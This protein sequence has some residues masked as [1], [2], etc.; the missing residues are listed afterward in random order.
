MPSKKVCVVPACQGAALTKIHIESSSL[1]E[2]WECPKCRRPYNCPTTLASIAPIASLGS[3]LAIVGSN[4]L[5]LGAEN[6][7]TLA[8]HITDN[9]EHVFDSIGDLFG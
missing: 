8:E 1:V 4:L 6:W 3:A 2:R 7:E 5:H 9:V